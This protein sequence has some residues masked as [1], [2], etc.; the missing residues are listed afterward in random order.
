MCYRPLCHAHFGRILM[1]PAC[2]RALPSS[3]AGRVPPT[4]R[5]GHKIN[6]YFL[7]LRRMKITDHGHAYPYILHGIYCFKDRDSR[8]HT[9]THLPPWV[10]LEPAGPRSTMVAVSL[11]TH[12]AW[13]WLYL[14]AMLEIQRI[15]KHCSNAQHVCWVEHLATKVH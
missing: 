5:R 11:S 6:K 7:N 8:S 9:R 4:C 14:V 13:W 15:L 10:P 12:A 3:R 2:V 1:R